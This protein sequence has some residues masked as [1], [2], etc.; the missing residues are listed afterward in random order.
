MLNLDEDKNLF[1]AIMVHLRYRITNHHINLP[2]T[3]LPGLELEDAYEYDGQDDQCA[4]DPSKVKVTLS[5]GQKLPTNET[6]LAQ[7]LVQHGPISIGINAN[8]MQF[9]YGGVSHPWKFLCSPASVD[10]G[11]LIVGFGEFV[12]F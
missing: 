5:G 11:V 10:H 12:L 9:Y 4:F 3:L 8:A 7:W 6:L 2:T 1:L